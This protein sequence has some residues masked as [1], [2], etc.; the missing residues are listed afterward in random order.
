MT[1][2][3]KHSETNKQKKKKKERKERRVSLGVLA[4]SVGL[5]SSAAAASALDIL[6]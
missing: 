6:L 1:A 3:T 4:Y 5:S 2:R